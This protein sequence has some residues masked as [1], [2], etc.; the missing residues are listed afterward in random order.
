MTGGGIK[1]MALGCAC[2]EA[3]PM[4]GGGAVG[5]A[6]GGACGG[7]PMRTVGA[8]SAAVDF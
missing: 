7:Q 4:R 5:G 6:M 2:A 1:K 8:G 3:G